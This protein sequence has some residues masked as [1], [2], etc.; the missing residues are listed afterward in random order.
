MITD[1]RVRGP[2]AAWW[3]WPPAAGLLFT[4]AFPPLD[5]LPLALVGLW[6]FLAFLDREEGL[7]PRAAF[8]G[9]YLFGLAHFGALLYWIAGLSGFSVMAVPA[10]VAS[11][12]ILAFNGGLTGVAVALGRR[13]GVSATVS[14]PLAWTAVEWLRSFGDLGVTWAVAGDTLASYPLLIQTAEMGGVWLLTLWVTGLSATLYRLA[15][16]LPA[17]RRLHV[18]LLAVVLAAV[19]PAYG[20]LR[21]AD[22]EA[23]LARW[24]TLRVAAVQPN[25]PQEVKWDP[26]FVDETY[27]RLAALT[28]QADERDPDLVVWPESAVPGYLRYDARARALVT[29]LSRRIEAPIFTGTNDADTLPGRTG[30]DPGD[31]RV[32]NAAYLVSGDSIL[33]G[34]YAKRRLVPVAERVPFLPGLLSGFF[35]KLSDWT[36]QFAPGTEWTTWSVE[37]HGFG[38]LICYESVFPGSSR[39]LVRN[40]ADFLLNITN[41]AWFGRTAAP[42]QHASHLALRSVENRVSFLRSANTGISGWVDPLGR[43]RERT[44]IY[45]PGVVVAD[46]PMSG[47]ETPYTRWGPW[48]P[49]VSLL[50]LGA[51]W[52][53]AP[54]RRR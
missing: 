34:R 44:G 14:F 15:R 27:R 31:Y 17:T 16:P 3:W 28:L 40:G 13:R 25:V 5:L 41:D 2:I 30:A 49:V 23:R 54:A 48:V 50:A 11:V 26:A 32:Y 8:V 18:A 21:L 35:E 12:L 10:Y 19:V 38:V 51:L 39:A 43:Y 7:R 9:G 37:G 22:L 33:P 1:A 52:L 46:L 29:G 4:L 36:G 24:P 53:V 42:Y 45:V 6:P 20:A 47:I